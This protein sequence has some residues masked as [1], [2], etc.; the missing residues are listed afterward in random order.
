M[1]VEQEQINDA[2]VVGLDLKNSYDHFLAASTYGGY[3]T[4]FTI[5]NLYWI[6][7]FLLKWVYY[8]SI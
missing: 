7:L 3:D 6:C 2:A 8:Y 1:F 5:F 4:W